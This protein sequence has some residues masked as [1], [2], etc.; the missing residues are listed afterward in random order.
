MHW[1]RG[2]PQQDAHFPFKFSKEA[3]EEAA[4]LR[5]DFTRDVALC[6]LAQSAPR[7]PTLQWASR[8]HRGNSSPGRCVWEAAEGKLWG[9]GLR[10]EPGSPGPCGAQGTGYLSGH[11]GMHLSQ[12]KTRPHPN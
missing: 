6:L 12:L 5:A 8:Q 7:P 9:Q 1:Y 11:A 2:F 3:S 4:W 10:Q